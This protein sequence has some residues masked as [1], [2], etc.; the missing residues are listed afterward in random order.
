MADAIGSSLSAD[1]QP[2]S[3]G[4]VWGLAAIWRSVCIQ[5]VNRVNSRSGCEP[6]WQHHKYRH[7]MTS[8]ILCMISPS[9]LRKDV[10]FCCCFN[11][12]FSDFCRTSYLNIYRTDHH[13][14]CTI[15]RWLALDIFVKLFYRFFRGSCRGNQICVQIA[16][17][18]F[19]RHWLG[20]RAINRNYCKKNL[21]RTTVSESHN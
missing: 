5:Q 10:M 15:G 20:R 8:Y 9:A 4:S 7:N 1:S 18:N 14:I 11:D 6:W 19:A 3:Y 16:T 13:E 2:R 12:Y 21:V 17:L